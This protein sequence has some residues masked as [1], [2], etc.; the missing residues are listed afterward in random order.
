MAYKS[1]PT[2]SVLTVSGIDGTALGATSIGTT[3]P[4]T[5]FVPL[6]V[7]LET[8]STTGFVTVAS[9][10]VGTNSTS[11]DNLLAITPMTGVIANNITIQLPVTALSSSV[12]ASTGIS[13]KVTT[14]AVATTYVL[15]AS[16]IGFYY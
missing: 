4:V 2:L 9:I 14:A 8:T 1:S 3:A 13:V 11:F 15:R 5:R 6:F 10:S 7:N 12:A 16:I